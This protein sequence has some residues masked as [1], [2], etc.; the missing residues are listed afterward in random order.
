MV[1][2]L[3]FDLTAELSTDRSPNILSNVIFL[4]FCCE[5]AARDVVI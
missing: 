3:N 4:V 5:R 1:A 2:H